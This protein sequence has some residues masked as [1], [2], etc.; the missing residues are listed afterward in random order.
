MGWQDINLKGTPLPSEESQQ[1]SKN[2]MAVALGSVLTNGDSIL[3]TQKPTLRIANEKD[4]NDCIELS[5]NS[6]PD[7]RA[8]NKQL[9]I[10]HI[11][12]CI[13]GGRCLVVSENN[14]VI[15]FLVWGQLRNKI[16]I[17]DIFVKERYRKEWIATILMQE[18]IRIAK[19]QWFKEVMSD[20]DVSNKLAIIFHLKFG[21]KKCGHIK[22]NWDDEDSHVFSLKI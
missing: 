18:A 1:Q 21:F 6:W 8:K 12:D 11:R 3:I 5:Q 14:E 15:A 13:W 19:D 17:Q 16:H 10:N 22:N 4:A 20:C 2:P 7:W 9:G